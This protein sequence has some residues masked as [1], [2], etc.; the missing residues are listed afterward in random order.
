MQIN[1]QNNSAILYSTG[2]STTL[3]HIGFYILLYYIILFHWF[4]FKIL[5]ACSWCSICVKWSR[6]FSVLAVHVSLS[7]SLS[8]FVCMYMCV[9]IYIHTLWSQ[10]NHRDH[11]VSIYIYICIYVYIYIYTHYGRIYIYIN[12][13]IYIYVEGVT[14]VLPSRL[15]MFNEYWRILALS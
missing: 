9:C 7:R 5:F 3:M 11:G 12:M 15:F 4:S 2:L 1:L 10:A 8:V 13:Y 14:L 6:V